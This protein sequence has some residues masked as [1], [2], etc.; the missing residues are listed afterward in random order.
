MAG[1]MPGVTTSAEF[2]SETGNLDNKLMHFAQSQSSKNSQ[3]RVAGIGAEPNSATAPVSPP[4]MELEGR[5]T[6]GLFP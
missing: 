4:G 6:A 1:V 2:P 3:P 5:G